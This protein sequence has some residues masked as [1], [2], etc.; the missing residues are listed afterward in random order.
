MKEVIN[1]QGEKE[2]VSI[3]TSVRTSDGIHY[4]HTSEEQIEIDDREAAVEAEQIDYETNHRYKDD[5]KKAYG[6]WEEQMERL[7]W[8]QVNNTTT[9]KD[10]QD[11]VRLNIP[12][13]I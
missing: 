11:T 5:R 12:K 3:D 7:Y 2:L 1:L 13:P 10:H 4:L 8:D 6:T 9:F